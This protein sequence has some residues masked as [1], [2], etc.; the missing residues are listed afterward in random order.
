[1]MNKSKARYWHVAYPLVITSICVAPHDYF[2]KHWMACF[3]AGVGKLKVIF[4]ALRQH[5]L[6]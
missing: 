2:L 6:A 1:M 3:E 4:I 5:D